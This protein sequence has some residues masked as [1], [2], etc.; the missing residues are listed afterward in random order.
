MDAIVFVPPIVVLS[1]TLRK[2]C[3]VEI[4]PLEGD[5]L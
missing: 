5:A 4:L 3:R 1:S 2:P